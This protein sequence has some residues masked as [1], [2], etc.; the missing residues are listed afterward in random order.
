MPKFQVTSSEMTRTSKDLATNNSEFKTRVGELV[1][2]QGELAA[3]WKGDANT[4]FNKAFTE[5]KS[6]WDAFATLVD[7][8][9]EALQNII[10]R[11]ER[12]EEENRQI[13]ASRR[14]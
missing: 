5:D 12:V 9:I 13:A 10:Q 7:Q 6:K 4:A 3:M 11:Y 14:S 2:L 1:K 8:Y